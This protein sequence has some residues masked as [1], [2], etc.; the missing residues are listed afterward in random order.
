[1]TF[2]KWYENRVGI[3]VETAK[4]ME[5]SDLQIIQA[6]WNAAIEAATTKLVRGTNLYNISGDLICDLVIDSIEKLKS[7]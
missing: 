6:A 5:V 3:S 4:L 2:E 1:M 7:S